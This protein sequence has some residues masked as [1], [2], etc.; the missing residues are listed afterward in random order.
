MINFRLKRGRNT[1]LQHGIILFF[2]GIVLFFT[3]PDS[4]NI[5]D[6][7]N[8]VYGI[9]HALSLANLKVWAVAFIVVSLVRFTALW[10]NGRSPVGSPIARIIS[11]V[12][13]SM[14]LVVFTM[15]VVLYPSALIVVYFVMLIFE[16]I[17]IWNATRDLKYAIDTP[18]T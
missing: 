12:V 7:F 16:L 15:D 4:I 5:L 13:T 17:I 8:L 3:S 10:I 11:A 2:M 9:G 6:K 14:L 18:T 1:E